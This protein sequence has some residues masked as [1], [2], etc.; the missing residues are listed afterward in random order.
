MKLLLAAIVLMVS[1]GW[2]VTKS[3]FTN[4]TPLRVTK[5]EKIGEYFHISDGYTVL[6]SSDFLTYHYVSGRPL[7]NPRKGESK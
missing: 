6:K 7:K 1:P 3:S 5:I 2:A 4:T